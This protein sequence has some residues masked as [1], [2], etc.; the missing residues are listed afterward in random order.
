[1]H[2]STVFLLPSRKLVSNFEIQSKEYLL[3]HCIE[4]HSCDKFQATIA[5][6]PAVCSLYSFFFLSKQTNKQ[7]PQLLVMAF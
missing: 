4:V 7:T 3:H 5:L 1:M 2:K 6:L